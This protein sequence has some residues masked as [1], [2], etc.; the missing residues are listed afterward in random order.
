MKGYFFREAAIDIL[1]DLA[2]AA[3]VPVD[4]SLFPGAFDNV[5]AGRLASDRAQ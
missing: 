2:G 4:F 5:G 1:I 3:A